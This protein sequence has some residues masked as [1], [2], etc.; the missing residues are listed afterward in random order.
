MWIFL[1]D[2]MLSI[3]EPAS[4]TPETKGKLVVRGRVTGD[5]K[6]VFPKARVQITPGRDY[7][8]RAL[9]ARSE[10][11]SALMR[12]VMSIDY[13]NFKDGVR[14]NKRH[15]TYFQVWSSMQRLQQ[16]LARPKG[17]QNLVRAGDDYP[18]DLLEHRHG[19]PPNR[20][21]GGL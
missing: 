8:F 11:A 12:E 14:E 4:G 3:V 19:F 15:D 10:V 5:I 18:G 7:R 21:R 17:A 16:D 6:R 2:A 9:V 13:T 20:P 1:Q